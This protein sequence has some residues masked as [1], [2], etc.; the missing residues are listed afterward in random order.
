MKTAVYFPIDANNSSTTKSAEIIMNY[1]YSGY[2]IYITLLQ[3]LV[4]TPTRTLELSKLKAIA[5]DMHL[6]LDELQPIVNDFFD[7]DGNTFYSDELNERMKWFDEKYNKASEGGKKTQA[8]Y[9]PEQKTENAKK[10]A[11]KRWNKAD[12]ANECEPLRINMQTPFVSD[13]NNK[14]EKNRI[15][16]KEKEEN[17]TEENRIEQNQKEE[18][19]KEEKNS[20]SSSHSKIKSKFTNNDNTKLNLLTA[21]SD[22]L[23]SKTDSKLQFNT[24]E[25]LLMLSIYHIEQSKNFRIKSWYEMSLLLNNFQYIQEINTKWIDVYGKALKLNI[26][27]IQTIHRDLVNHFTN[28]ANNSE[29]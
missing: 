25:D 18:K 29:L 16:Q 21:Y 2:G 3:K 9:T 12:N 5:F 20:V 19:Q 24:Y 28:K 1:G 22:Y 13:A 15:E 27:N 14:I 7:I 6:T 17:K 11:E 4:S 10:L 23:I 8:K 26:E